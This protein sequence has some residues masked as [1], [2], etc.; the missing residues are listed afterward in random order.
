MF[1][2]STRR[3]HTRCTRQTDGFCAEAIG[4]RRKSPASLDLEAEATEAL[5]SLAYVDELRAK[6]FMHCMQGRTQTL[7]EGPALQRKKGEGLL[8]TR[9]SRRIR[10]SFGQGGT[11]SCAPTRPR[12][13]LTSST[14]QLLNLW[15]RMKMAQAL[16]TCKPRRKRRLSRPRP[17]RQEAFLPSCLQTWPPKPRLS[18]S[19]RRPSAS[20]RTLHPPRRTAVQTLRFSPSARKALQSLA[21]K[22]TVQSLE[23]RFKF[24]ECA[25][26]LHAHQLPQLQ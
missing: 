10:F 20:L 1:L 16:R 9:R 14:I 3:T 6:R 18:P 24:L 11:A 15:G 13:E 17:L 23:T 8:L 12:A 7:D 19:S 21:T 25:E 26:R 22:R 4:I 5:K 2:R